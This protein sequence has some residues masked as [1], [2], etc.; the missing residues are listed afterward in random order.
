MKNKLNI[1]ISIIASLIVGLLFIP[2]KV[3]GGLNGSR[4]YGR[5][6]IINFISPNKNMCTNCYTYKIS[7]L[8]LLLEVILVFG[9]AL[10]ILNIIE[11]RKK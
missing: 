1:L 3:T 7:W 4:V 2:I 9:I 5:T 6:S 11:K 10:I 8:L